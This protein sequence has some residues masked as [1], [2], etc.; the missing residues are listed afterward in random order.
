MPS[1]ACHD[2]H[3]VHPFDDRLVA[4]RWRPAILRCLV[5]GES[6]GPPGAEYFYDASQR[7][8]RD[9]IAIRRNILRGL[10]ELGILGS[11]SVGAFVEAGFMLDHAIRCQLPLSTVAR[12]RSRASRFRSRLVERPFHLRDLI[13]RAERVWVMGHIA[14]NAV[15]NLGVELP[16]QV[17]LD[18]PSVALDG[19]TFVSRYLN[20]LPPRER[21]RICA[22]FKR[23]FESRR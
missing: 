21:L 11:P 4:E 9:R 15:R 14:R 13:S 16:K 8:D 19:R 2:C 18:P 17:A 23:F 22:D 20:H 1:G 12:E 6:P 10:T 5:I 3:G 7:A